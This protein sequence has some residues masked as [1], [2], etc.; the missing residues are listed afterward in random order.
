MLALVAA[1]TYAQATPA[2]KRADDVE[3]PGVQK[4]LRERHAGFRSFVTKAGGAWTAHFNERSGA[5]ALIYGDG[6]PVS[7]SGIASMEA[8]EAA[9]TATLL[10]FPELW[11]APVAQLQLTAKVKTGHLYIFTWTQ[12]WD[13]L[14]VRGARV[15]IQVHETGRVAALVAEGVAIPGDFARVP[16]L[17]PGEA[18]NIVKRGKRLVAGDT[19]DA[20]DF[21]IFTKMENA[22]ATPRLAYRVD[23]VQPWADVNER[24]YVDAQDGSILEVE[25]GHYNFDVKGRVTGTV[26]TSL[27]GGAAPTAGIP[28]ANITVNVAGLGTAVTDANGDYAITTALA[29]PF[30]VSAQLTG[31]KFNINTAQGTKLS[32]AATT[33]DVGGVQVGDLVFN[34]AGDQF[35]TAQANAAMHHTFIFNYIKSKLPSFN[36]FG[37]QGVTTN[38]ASTC[39]AYFDPNANTL[40]FYN[41]GGGCINSAYSTVL[42][43]EFGHGVDDYY[44]GIVNGGLS[45]GIGDVI[46]M[47]AT[48]S[49]YVGIGFQGSGTAIRTGENSTSWPAS[50]CGGEVHCLGQT[51]MGF[52]WQ[53]YKLL[54]QALGDA[55]GIAAAENA[56]LGSL[57]ANSSTIPNAVTQAFILDDNDGNLN[58]GTPNY[59]SLAAAAQMKGFTPPVITI[60][61]ISISHEPHPDT[62]SQSRPYPIFATMA[63]SGGHAVTGATVLYSVDGGAVQQVPMQP[64]FA[65]GLFVG[66]IPPATGPKLISYWVRGTDDVNNVV[67]IPAGD[68]AFRFA[69]GRKTVLFSSDLESG[70]AGWTHVQVKVQDDWNWGKPQTLGTNVYDPKTAWSGE[71]FWG[72]DLQ[73]QASNQD[74]L[75]KASVENYIETPSANASGHTGVRVRFRRW[76]TV[77]SGQYDQAEVYANNSKLWSNPL[78][79]DLLDSSWTLQDLAAPAADNAANFRV[80]WR[81]VSDPGLQYGGWNFDDVEVYSLEATPVLNMNITPVATNVLIGNNVTLNMTGTPLGGYEIYVSL[82]PGPGALDGYGAFEAGLSAIGF[83]ASG[84]FNAA[85][86]AQLYFP[87]P[88]DPIL[89]GLTFY[90][91]GGVSVPNA[92]PQIS[93]VVATSFQ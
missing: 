9:A 57:P 92:L 74:G 35:G 19:V 21:M 52:A 62:F 4:A 18:E 39:N 71:N 73:N 11:G 29:G 60:L 5:P 53:A 68:S 33:S 30:N 32:A 76:L 37:V 78:L 64:S 48:G 17:G 14:A 31:P 56:L 79:T 47:Y 63:A 51:Y 61:P 42:Y 6:L 16:P 34:I 82:D 50:S 59:A 54:K 75:Y 69:V 38:I 44:S 70:A 13:G 15:Q 36:G 83:V 12:T 7:Q 27:D 22:K 55:A 72:N 58:N 26:N 46:A 80:R 24:V 28:L 88:Y 20:A 1:P 81:L 91:V 8:A 84:N 65:P 10:E 67:T 93:N 25:P 86:Y 90:W 66:Y 45:E 85:G 87:I 3:H 89:Q 43:H 23:V 41:A 40:N 2:P 49:P 77:E